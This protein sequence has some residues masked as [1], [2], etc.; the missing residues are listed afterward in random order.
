MTDSPLVVTIKQLLEI[1]WPG[2]VTI[3][4]YLIARQYMITVEAEINYLRTEVKTLQDELI[5]VKKQLL[6][7]QIAAENRITSD[8]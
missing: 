8:K 3:A 7:A 5:S 2:L 4:V 1:G 6:T